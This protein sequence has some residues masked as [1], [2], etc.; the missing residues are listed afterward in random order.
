MDLAFRLG[1]ES[2]GLPGKSGYSIAMKSISRLTLSILLLSPLLTSLIACTADVDPVAKN[3]LSASPPVEIGGARPAA[4]VLPEDYSPSKRYPLVVMLHGYGAN[5]IAQDVVFGLK[6]RATAKQFILVMP[7]GTKDPTG[8]RYWNADPHNFLPKDVDDVGYLTGLL[9]EAE[10]IYAVEPKRIAFVGH[11]LG[12]YMTY[13]MACEI[14]DRINRIAVL[15]GSLSID[16]KVCKGTLPVTVLHMHG[17]ADEIVPYA[18]HLTE[19]TDG[20]FPIA[21]IGA[22]ATIGRWLVKDGCP[23]AWPTPAQADLT[24]APGDETDV[25]HWGNCSS[26]KTIELWRIGGADHL[27]LDA[28]ETYR[29]RLATYL[30]GEESP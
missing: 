26:G 6:K 21:T 23:E 30:V 8:K 22:E 12:G 13:R 15:A 29:D 7:E 16:P 24:S 3:A 17:T 9:D 4:V 18:S 25:F 20:N 19:P 11:S 28:N 27:L 10:R 2:F 5:A 1:G 14:P